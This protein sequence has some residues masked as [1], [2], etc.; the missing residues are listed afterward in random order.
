MGALPLGARAHS[1]ANGDG[2][3][4]KSAP[5]F[6]SKTNGSACCGG[7]LAGPRKGNAKE[8]ELSEVGRTD[9]DARRPKALKSDA[10]QVG[11]PGRSSRQTCRVTVR[12]SGTPVPRT[13]THTH[14]RVTRLAPD[15][16]DVQAAIGVCLTRAPSV[17]NYR[18]G[19]GCGTPGAAGVAG[20]E[21]ELWGRKSEHRPSGSPDETRAG[22]GGGRATLWDSFRFCPTTHADRW[23]PDRPA[24]FHRSMRHRAVGQCTAFTQP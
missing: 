24:G 19:P 10:A 17:G 18:Q 7:G 23:Y 8:Q 20:P 1:D 5:D 12:A 15:R 9:R 14:T 3:L 11:G 16:P 22:W 6:V 13:V 2:P 4:R 21:K